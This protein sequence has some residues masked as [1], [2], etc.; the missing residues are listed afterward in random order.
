MLTSNDANFSK[1]RL[2]KPPYFITFIVTF[3]QVTSVSLQAA[4]VDQVMSY[5][6]LYLEIS[7][8]YVGSICD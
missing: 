2:D 6:R 1:H 8:A 4:R 5:T 3:A 7:S